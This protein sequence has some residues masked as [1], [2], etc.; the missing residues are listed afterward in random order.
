M[1]RGA[2]A[3]QLVAALMFSLVLLVSLKGCGSGGGALLPISAT[4][5]PTATPTA[6]PTPTPTPTATPT[7]TPTPTPTPTATPTSG[8]LF[9]SPD[10]G[11]DGSSADSPLTLEQA[12]DIAASGATLLLQGGTYAQALDLTTPGITIRGVSSEAAILAPSSTCF[13]VAIAAANITL[14]NL[15]LDGK[16]IGGSNCTSAAILTGNE[17]AAGLKL[18]NLTILGSNPEP[19]PGSVNLPSESAPNGIQLAGLGGAT[20]TNLQ[21]VK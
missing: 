10:G 1:Q 19:T 18:N 20:L 21:P 14:E 15:T 2:R 9:V 4:P 7:A 6:T 12:L 5:T 3:D 17:A 16:D 13:G 11:G 8:L